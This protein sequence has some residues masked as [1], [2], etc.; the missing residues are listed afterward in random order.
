MGSSDRA[1]RNSRDGRGAN[2]PAKRKA[3]FASIAVIMTVGLLVAAGE[4]FLLVFNPQVSCFPRWEFSPEYGLVFPRNTTIVHKRP[5]RWEFRY[6]MNEYGCRGKA[7]PLS[8]A[9]DK[10][11]VV[12]LGDSYAMGTAVADGEEFPA[13]IAQE[14][15][16]QADVIN[17]GIGGWGLTQQIRR[18]YAFGRLYDPAI[19]ILQFCMNDP[20]ENLDNRVTTVKNGRFVFHNSTHSKSIVMEFLSRSYIAQHSQLY[21]FFRNIQWQRGEKKIL[22]RSVRTE[23]GNSS[24]VSEPSQAETFY[25]ELIEA[26]AVDLHARG[27]YFLM[28]SVQGQLNKYPF[29]KGKVAEL[30]SKG[31]IDYV[32]VEDWLRNETDIRSPEGHWN[33]RAHAIVGRNLSRIIKEQVLFSQ[34]VQSW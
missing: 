8:N 9:Y 26:F 16:D 7:V 3:L 31:L 17:T 25:N 13:I 34:R 32:E 10:T 21:I 22:A 6:T 29:I 20:I 24:H 18:F 33:S 28:I 30:E 12:V 23:T 27:I 2:P 1:L 14:L 15:G 19:V 4:L 5:G 11:N